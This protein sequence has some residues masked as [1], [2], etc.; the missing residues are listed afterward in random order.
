MVNRAVRGGSQ[1]FGLLRLG[2]AAVC[3]AV[4]VCVASF[5]EHK[6]GRTLASDIVKRPSKR[7]TA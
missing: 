5:K 1:A 6:I 7:P 4:S 3:G 2:W